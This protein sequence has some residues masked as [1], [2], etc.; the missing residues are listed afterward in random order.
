MNAFVIA[1]IVV[2]IVILISISVVV[3]VIFKENDSQHHKYKTSSGDVPIQTTSSP[4]PAAKNVNIIRYV[5]I[6]TTN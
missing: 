3:L 2:G 6:Q 4:V 1:G 5:P